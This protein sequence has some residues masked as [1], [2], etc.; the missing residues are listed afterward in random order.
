MKHLKKITFRKFL[1]I[2]GLFLFVW[3]VG[4]I[5]FDWSNI[6]ID[7]YNF[8]QLE[9][10]KKILSYYPVENYNF[11]SLSEFNKKYGGD[12]NPK[13]N[14]YFLMATGLW[15]SY[16][17]WFELESFLYKLF[18]L[19]FYYVYPSTLPQDIICDGW[20]CHD[21]IYTYFLKIISNPCKD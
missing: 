14:C 4:Y 2:L 10:A 13:M 6:Q 20:S 11:N 8:E 16:R 19:N 17:F 7:R 15:K 18:Y 3:I 9:K 12:I 21:W 1:T 5:A